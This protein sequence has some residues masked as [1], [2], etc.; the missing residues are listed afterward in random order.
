MNSDEHDELWN[1]LGKARQSFPA[2]FLARNILRKIRTQQR[3]PTFFGQAF[4]LLRKWRLATLGAAAVALLAV[5]LAP[6]TKKQGEAI[7]LAAT[8]YE[9]IANLDELLAS[10]ENSLW[11]DTTQD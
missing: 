7:Q 8:D 4:A 2:P 11:T 1:L 10:Q 5:N 6:H 3:R 9:V